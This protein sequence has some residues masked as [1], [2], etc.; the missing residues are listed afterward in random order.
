M[1]A[2]QRILNTFY[3]SISLLKTKRSGTFIL[4]VTHPH[5]DDTVEDARKELVALPYVKSLL[6][7]FGLGLV[8]CLA[9]L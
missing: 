2:L 9:R 6:T 4:P 1:K 3:T 8:L 5:R 7:A